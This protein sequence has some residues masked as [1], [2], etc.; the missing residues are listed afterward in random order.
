MIV[1]AKGVCHR[2]SEMEK[3]YPGE[4][5]GVFRIS[6]ST[7]ES[8]LKC[9]VRFEFEREQSYRRATIA[10]LIGTAVSSAAQLDNHLKMHGT[11]SSSGQLG[12]ELDDMIGVAVSS[13]ETNADDSEV[14]ESK[15]E[16]RSGVDTVREAARA[17]GIHVSP[18]ITDVVATE[19]PIIAE[20]EDGLE[21]AGTPDCIQRAPGAAG[22]VQDTKT[23][24]PW[25]QERVDASRQLTGYTLLHEAKYGVVPDRVVIHSLSKHPR[26]FRSWRSTTLWS[27]RDESD[28]DAYVELMRRTRRSIEAGIALP[29]PSNAWWCSA[30]WC[31]FAKQCEFFQGEK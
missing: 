21:L 10:M 13:F 29:A 23:G 20:I 9:G 12:A 30:K 31:P 6:N 2:E 1:E 24:Q 7:I 28:R 17:Y 14:V 26:T 16:Q 8:Y 5:E 15:Q 4:R 22:T 18:T 19:E 27:H 11:C 3:R 25:T